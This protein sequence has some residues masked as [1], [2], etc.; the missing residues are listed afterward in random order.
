VLRDL[1]QLSTEEAAGA[2]DLGVPA[3]KARL[4]RGRLM[5]REAL[6]PHFSGQV[7]SP[8]ARA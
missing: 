2:L 6:A 8:D 4:I 1:Q 3:L 5:L 7:S